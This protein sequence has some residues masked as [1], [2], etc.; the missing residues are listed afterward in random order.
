[1]SLLNR[2]FTPDEAPD[3]YFYRMRD[4]QLF[5]ETVDNEQVF[6]MKCNRSERTFVDDVRRPMRYDQGAMHMSVAFE[7]EHEETFHSGPALRLVLGGAEAAPVLV[8]PTFGESPQVAGHSGCRQQLER[9]PAAVRSAR[10][11]HPSSAVLQR[12]RLAVGVLVTI[13]L[14]ALALPLSAL[15]GRAVHPAT[16]TAVPVSLSGHQGPYYVVQPGDT[17]ASIAARIDPSNPSQMAQRLATTVGS[18]TIV[19]GEHIHLP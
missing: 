12:R 2:I 1:M 11:R 15:G 17:L 19:P 3:V 5:E 18:T 8:T 7:L 6:V 16:T 9:D 10:S 13:V 4:E 14:I